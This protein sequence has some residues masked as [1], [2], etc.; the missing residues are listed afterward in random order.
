MQ[1]AGV[2]RPALILLVD[3]YADALEMYST[4]LEYAGF[5]CIGAKDGREA[6]GHLRC[7]RPALI[8]MDAT[9]PGMDGWEAT[10]RIK[11]DP[12]TCDIPLLILTAHSHP[13]HRLRAAETGAD[14]FLTKPMAPEDLVIAIRQMLKE[15]PRVT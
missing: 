5:E 14:G 10:R 2:E 1:S 15:H 13:E 8:V 9:M 3:D 4:Y 12:L 7:H 11:D 6:L